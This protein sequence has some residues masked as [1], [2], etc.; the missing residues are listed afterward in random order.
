MFYQD[1]K[2]TFVCN[3][4]R[5]GDAVEVVVVVLSG[6]Q[7]YFCMQYTTSKPL[8]DLHRMLCYQDFKDTFVCNTQH[9]LIA[10][11]VQLRCVIRI[12]K[13]LLYAIHNDWVRLDLLSAVVLSGFQR[14]FCMQYTTSSIAVPPPFVLCYQDFNEQFEGYTQPVECHGAVGSVV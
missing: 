4:Q 5:G 11:L 3:T 13:I 8:H 1:L 7:R 10:F 14:Y 9:S 2:D 6:S 12:S